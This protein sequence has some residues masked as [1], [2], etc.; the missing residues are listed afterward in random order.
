MGG[1]GLGLLLLLVSLVAGVIGLWAFYQ[2]WA[3]KADAAARVR[4]DRGEP[5]S[6]RLKAWIEPRVRRTALGR[7]LGLVISAAGVDLAVSD[8][9]AIAV[10][11]FLIVAGAVRALFPLWLSLAAGAAALWFCWMWLQRLREKRREQFM[12][13]LP[14]LA[15]VLS[16]CSQAGL[17]LR[18]AIDMAAVELDAPAGQEMDLVARELRL[19]QAIDRAMQNLDE[20]M[21]SREVSVLVA[22]LVIQQRAGGDLVRALR[23][24]AQT[25]EARKDLRREVRTIMAGAVYT[26]YIV[27]V[28]GIGSLVLVNT[29]SPGALQAMANNPLGQVA[30]II[31]AGLYIL[32]FTL[33][34]RTTRIDT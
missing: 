34:R 26:S 18:S 14:D 17:S 19:G 1:A 31:S 33:I 23:D 30:M 12:A 7:R 4:I 5:R 24:M 28:L 3:T 22:T 27:A 25:L 6:G 13:Q 21:P 32:G 15:R 29:I 20:R 2:G 8:A 16:N 11:A 9:I 10:G